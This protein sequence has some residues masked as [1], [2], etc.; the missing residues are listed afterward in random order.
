MEAGYIYSRDLHDNPIVQARLA[1]LKRTRQLEVARIGSGGDKSSPVA[2][3]PTVSRDQ[4][5]RIDEVAGINAALSGAADLS[6]SRVTEA[7]LLANPYELRH[8][9]RYLRDMPCALPCDLKEMSRQSLTT[10]LA[11]TAFS[12]AICAPSVV[13]SPPLKVLEVGCGTAYWSSSC[14]THFQSRGHRNV[15]FTGIDI[16]PTAPD[17]RKHGVDWQYIQHDI[18]RCPWPFADGEF[19]LVMIKDMSLALPLGTAGQSYI[20]ECIR[21]LREGGTLEI[22]ESDHV[23]RSLPADSPPGPGTIVRDDQAIFSTSSGTSFTAAQDRYVKQS[24]TWIEAAL[25]K[26]NL[27]SKPCS[28]VVEVLHGLQEADILRDS[29]SRRI[30]IPLRELPWE[31]E[32]PLGRKHNRTGTGGRAAVAKNPVRGDEAGLTPDQIAMRHT[33]LLIVL[34][35]IESLEPLLKEISGKSTEEWASWWTG[36]MSSLLQHDGASTGECLEIGAWWATKSP[37]VR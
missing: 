29:G 13:A 37:T 35:K 31:K 12:G 18:R 27:P 1:E 19:D 32:L 3:S 2:T 34:Q 10:L 14:N 24:N 22:W 20:D 36:M 11:V 4:S 21:V 33:A 17:M 25:A 7:E 9:R 30:A 16:A 6:S 23:L 8:G 5:F 15:S 26:R 28:E